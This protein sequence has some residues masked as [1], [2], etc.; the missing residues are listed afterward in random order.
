[1]PTL[2]YPEVILQKKFQLPSP[3]GS[4]VVSGQNFIHVAKLCRKIITPTDFVLFLCPQFLER[5]TPKPTSIAELKTTLLMI[6]NDLPPGNYLH[7]L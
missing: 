2:W 1:M 7:P 6:W 3:S 4:G 5:Y